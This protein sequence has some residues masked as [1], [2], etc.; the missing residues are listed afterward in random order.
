MA[1]PGLSRGAARGATDGPSGDGGPVEFP[2]ASGV[3]KV[4]GVLVTEEMI[5]ARRSRP[6]AGPTWIGAASVVVR[7][8]GPGQVV[9]VRSGK[10]RLLPATTVRARPCQVAWS[11][12]RAVSP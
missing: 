12:I 1:G 6:S 5:E 7:R 3:E 10:I 8:D 4:S 9:P 2:I 11:L